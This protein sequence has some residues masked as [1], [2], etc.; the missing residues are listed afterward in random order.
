MVNLWLTLLV[1][2]NASHLNQVFLIWAADNYPIHLRA[3][4]ALTLTTVSGSISHTMSQGLLL[5]GDEC[6]HLELGVCPVWAVGSSVNRQPG[7]GLFIWGIHSPYWSSHLHGHDLVLLL[8][9]LGFVWRTSVAHIIR[10]VI[11][12][13]SLLTT[14]IQDRGSPLCLTAKGRHHET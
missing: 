3:R 8:M 9:G 5:R 2:A 10:G 4:S 11:L 13:A 6:A 12:M 1:M 7:K 14:C